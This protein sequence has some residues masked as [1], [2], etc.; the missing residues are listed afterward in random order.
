MKLTKTIL[1]WLYTITSGLLETNPQ[2]NMSTLC[3]LSLLT[4]NPLFSSPSCL[5]YLSWPWFSSTKWCCKSPLNC[6]TCLLTGICRSER[7]WPAQ[8]L[9]IVI[10][11]LYII[12]LNLI[13]LFLALVTGRHTLNLSIT[14]TSHFH[15][16][17]AWRVFP[18]V[19]VKEERRHFRINQ[20]YWR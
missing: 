11:I 16:S 17:K 2:F 20:T 5:S 4:P 9:Q 1:A 18:C 3:F 8:V 10:L 6:V 15:K 14:I 12:P 13:I 19:V 7:L